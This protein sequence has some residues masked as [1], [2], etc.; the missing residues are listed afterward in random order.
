MGPLPPVF[1]GHNGGMRIH[2]P[3]GKWI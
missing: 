1:E 2:Y 3:D